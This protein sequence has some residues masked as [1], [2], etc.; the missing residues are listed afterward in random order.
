MRGSIF[1]GDVAGK[2]MPAAL[3]MAR[4]KSLI[5]VVTELTASGGAPADPAAIIARV[6][7][8][9][10]Q[11]NDAMMFV[12]LFFGI[13]S[14]GGVLLYCNAGHNPPYRIANGK[15]QPLDG[16][17]GI[18]L[19]VEPSAVYR[20]ARV[21]LAP[22]DRLFLFTDGVTEAFNAAE[23]AFGEARL[24]TAL[25][26]AAPTSAAIIEAVTAALAAFVGTAPRSDDV[27]MLALRRAAV[28]A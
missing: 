25:A 24:E 20:T 15:V 28:I 17:A 12:T 27:A 5:R 3:F 16:E 22:D 1:I 6:N 2:G 14:P 10:T 19:G 4:T 18:V 26:R 8:E 9:L 11:S 21:A 7:T 13:L 23:E